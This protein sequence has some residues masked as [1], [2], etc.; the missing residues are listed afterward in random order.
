[1]NKPRLAILSTILISVTLASLLSI[2]LIRAQ[3]TVPPIPPLFI[4]TAKWICNSPIAPV[5]QVNI[6]SAEDVGLVAGEYKTDINI[7][8]GTFSP[9]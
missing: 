7:H 3:P 2:S 1:M 9:Q 8:N 6:T 5:Q 4:Y